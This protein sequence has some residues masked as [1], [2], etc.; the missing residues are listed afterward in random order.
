MLVASFSLDANFNT[1]PILL[2][3]SPYVF[4]SASLSIHQLNLLGFPPPLTN[5]ADYSL[6]FQQDLPHH[7]YLRLLSRKPIWVDWWI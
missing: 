1:N 3:Y 4:F 6:F 5:C 2:A 7:S